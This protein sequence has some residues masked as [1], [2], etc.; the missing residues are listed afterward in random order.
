MLFEELL[1]ELN[2]LQVGVEH[3]GVCVAEGYDRIGE[4]L[5]LLHAKVA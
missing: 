2:A 3:L 5:H 4:F 1:L